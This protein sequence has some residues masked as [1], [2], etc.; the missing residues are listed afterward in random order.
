MVYDVV[1]IRDP[2]VAGFPRSTLAVKFAKFKKQNEFRKSSD[3][4]GNQKL[5]T[6]SANLVE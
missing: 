4:L 2:A 5:A 1:Y 6:L 3:F